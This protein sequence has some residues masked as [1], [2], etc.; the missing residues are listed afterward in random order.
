MREATAR[1]ARPM[2]I[3]H[4]ASLAAVLALAI[5]ACAGPPVENAERTAACKTSGNQKMCLQ[6][7]NT[8]SATYTQTGITGACVCVGDVQKP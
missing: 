3:T 2:K 6:C 1:Y 4:I 7:C 8:K 5:A